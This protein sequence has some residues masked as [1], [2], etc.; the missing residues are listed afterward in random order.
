MRMQQDDNTVP[1]LWK[2]AGNTYEHYA[3]HRAW[4]LAQLQA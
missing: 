3:E 1:L 4:I 2:I